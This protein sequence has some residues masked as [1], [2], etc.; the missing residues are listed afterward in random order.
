LILVADSSAIITLSICD[1]LEILESMFGEIKVP[2]AVYTEVTAYSK[3]ESGN[4]KLFLKD[5]IEE[6]NAEDYFIFEGS[7]GSGETEAMALYRKLNANWLLV[8]DEKARK[9]AHLNQIRVI[10]S[11]GVLVVAKERRLIKS[12]LPLIEK[13]KNSHTYFAES[14]LRKAI[15]MA[16]ES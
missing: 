11:L 2:F 16:G 15:S 7:L 14:L 3:P 1:C 5:K 13:V 10:G 12:I 9:I 6:I 8:D 4:L